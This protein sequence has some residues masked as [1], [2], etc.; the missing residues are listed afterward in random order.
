MRTRPPTSTLL[1]YPTLSISIAA[2]LQDNHVLAGG[3][4]LG[5]NDPATRTGADDDGVAAECRV[6][7]D[8]DRPDRLWGPGWWPQRTR[9]AD[10]A[11]RSGRRVM[12]DGRQ[13]F[14]CLKCFPALR[15]AARR[16]ASQALFALHR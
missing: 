10:G 4:E 14:Q 9:I 8:D 12:R 5:R 7:R 2:F 15:H 1:P 13:P 11:G 6:C 16:P 3:R